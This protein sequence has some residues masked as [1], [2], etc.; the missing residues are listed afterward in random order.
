MRLDVPQ[1][2]HLSRISIHVVRFPVGGLIGCPKSS[3]LAADVV[4]VDESHLDLYREN[5][6]CALESCSG[7]LLLRGPRFDR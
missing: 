1:T 2:G 5:G 6:E 7:L 4:W 3:S